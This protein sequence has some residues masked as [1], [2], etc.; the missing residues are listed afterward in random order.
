MSGYNDQVKE[1]PLFTRN[2]RKVRFKL[3]QVCV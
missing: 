3:D 2:E 1:N